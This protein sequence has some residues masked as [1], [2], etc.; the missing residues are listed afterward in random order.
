VIVPELAVLLHLALSL[1]L[2]PLPMKIDASRGVRRRA[3]CQETWRGER[4]GG[5]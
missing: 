3:H 4:I 1:C 2:N 5:R